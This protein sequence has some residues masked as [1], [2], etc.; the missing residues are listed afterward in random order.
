MCHL[1]AGYVCMQAR[2]GEL[3]HQHA[4]TLQLL[5]NFLFPLLKLVILVLVVVGLCEGLGRE[6]TRSQQLRKYVLFPLRE[7]VTHL[8]KIRVTRL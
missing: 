3:S 6:A 8:A 4:T 1:R 7:R 2:Q 5:Y